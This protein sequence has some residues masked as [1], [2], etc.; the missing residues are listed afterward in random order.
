MLTEKRIKQRHGD[1]IDD[2]RAEKEQHRRRHQEGQEGRALVLV[3]AG[4]DEL[5]DLR[6]DHRE[7]EEARPERRHLQLHEEELE[8]MGVD[9]LRLGGVADRLHVGPD[10][11]VVDR[12]GDPEAGE[13]HRHEGDQ[14][15][16]EALAQLDEVIDE[17]GPRG[18]DVVAAAVR[19]LGLHML[20]ALAPS[21]RM[22]GASAGAAG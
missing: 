5:V 4:G 6:G 21:G 14:R 9:H 18:L 1:E 20:H 8:R 10:Q 19:L 2:Q 12:D 7:G 11:D 13:E 15:P 3:E 17:R 22:A 16:D